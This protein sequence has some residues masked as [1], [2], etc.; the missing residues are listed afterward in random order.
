MGATQHVLI[1]DDDKE[2]CRVIAEYLDGEGLGVSVAHDG[3]DIAGAV[4][5]NS[6]D[7]V[8]LDI[9]LPRSDGLQIARRLR[10]EHPHV[11]IIMLTGRSATIDRII[12]L[13]MGAD[14]YLAKPFHLRELLAR[15]KSV[16][17][18]AN[19]AN[20]TPAA[21]G[22]PGSRLRFAGW[23]LDLRMRELFSPTG[24]RVSLTSGEFALLVAFV[25]HPNRLLTR[26]RL[27]EIVHNREPGPFDRTIDVQVGRLR[28]KLD[29]DPKQPRLIKTLRAAGYLFI[30]PVETVP[31]GAAGESLSGQTQPRRSSPPFPDLIRGAARG[32]L[33]TIPGAGRVAGGH[34]DL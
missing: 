16:T 1:V 23:H 5:R 10:D 27:L 4:A 17:R 34:D 19:A 9:L 32:P 30:A 28:R 26:D 6:I 8:L 25:S 18:R 13:E 14:D 29:D 31:D 33:S 2:I 20:D 22:A 12:G 21:A 3:A 15:I 24:G 7:I 11:G